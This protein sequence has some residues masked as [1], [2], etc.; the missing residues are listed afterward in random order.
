MIW[1]DNMKENIT[2]ELTTNKLIHKS[3]P[4]KTAFLHTC[5]ICGKA[6]EVQP[7]RFKG[8][9]EVCCSKLCG[10][11]WRKK[12]TNRA[13]LQCGNQMVVRPNEDKRFCSYRCAALFR[14]SLGRSDE[15]RRKLSEYG[16]RRH[17]AHCKDCGGFISKIKPH[18]CIVQRQVTP[19][20]IAKRIATFKTNYAAGKF[21]IALPIW[22]GGTRDEETKK[23][24]RETKK[25][26]WQDKNYVAKMVFV[27]GHPQYNTG[28][29][30]FTVDRVKGPNNHNWKGGITPEKIRIRHTVEYN[31][32]RTAVFKRDNYTCQL[33]HCPYCHNKPSGIEL[34]AHHIKRIYTNPSLIYDIDNGITFCKKGHLAYH[35][36]YGMRPDYKPRKKTLGTIAYNESTHKFE[37]SDD[38]GT[39]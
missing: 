28:R 34:R 5:P 2:T 32:W 26:N 10:H 6:F 15:T 7:Y 27:K 13:C 39:Y 31:E 20:E 37:W 8:Q 18:I 36:Q 19:E 29:T 1:G 25:K 17:D 9:Q 30:H 21:K 23:K 22:T 38:D 24:I 33:I 12:R 11:A 35:T 4:K 14:G 3:S 16:K